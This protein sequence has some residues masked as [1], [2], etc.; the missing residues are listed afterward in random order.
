MRPIMVLVLAVSAGCSGR[1]MVRECGAVVGNHSSV[2]EFGWV[3]PCHREDTEGCEDVCRHAR[4]AC[5]E[6]QAAYRDKALWYDGPPYNVPESVATANL[7]HLNIKMA[8]D[9]PR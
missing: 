4:S 9:C 6:D 5:E 8:K 3:Q 2:Q 1:A 7:E